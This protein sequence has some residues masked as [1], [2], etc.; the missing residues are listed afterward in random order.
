MLPIIEVRNI[1]KRYQLGAAF[2]RTET[3]RELIQRKARAPWN[4]ILGRKGNNDGVRGKKWFWALQDINFDV[5]EGEVLGVIG[6]NGAGKSTLLKIMSRITDPTE[7]YIKMRGRLASLLEVGTGFHSELTGRENIF[8]NGAILGMR[9]S[10]IVSKF[11]EIVAF[12]EVGKFLDTPVK[13]YSSGMYVRLAFAVAAHLNPEILVID[14]VLAVGDAAFQKKCLGKMSDVSRSGRTVLFVSHNMATVENLCQHAIVLE[15]GKMVF[16]GPAKEAVQHYLQRLNATGQGSGSHV[17]DL[18]SAVGR[19]PASKPLLQ[20]L[21]FYTTDNEPLNCLK[22]GDPLKIR[23]FFRLENP[24]DSFDIG[25]GFNN[26]YGLRMFTAHTF[27]EPDRSHGKKVGPQ[28]FVCDI[29]SLTL[30]PGDYALRIWLDVNS[31]EADLIEDAARITIVESD[32]Y[33][34]GK[35]PWNGAMVLKHRWY[36]EQQQAREAEVG[37]LSSSS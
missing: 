20:K 36:L 28:I 11:D 2:R 1:S 31:F 15:Q 35:M 12:S 9:K 7:G 8:L 34:S 27:F 17:V 29:P 10:E 23:V 32:Y 4:A 16:N 21:E 33:G 3:F 26:M 13:H 30:T 24:T 19:S 25:I 37:T 14:E 18:C 6:R 5:R 22:I